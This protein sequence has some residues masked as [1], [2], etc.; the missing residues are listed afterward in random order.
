M[1][2]SYSVLIMPLL[3][4]PRAEQIRSAEIEY[5]LISGTHNASQTETYVIGI[6]SM[7]LPVTVTIKPTST[8]SYHVLTAVRYELLTSLT[9]VSEARQRVEQEVNDELN[10]VI[11][12]NSKLLKEEHTLVWS[13]V[14]H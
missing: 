14:K 8:W 6:A 13:K 12:I 10:A 7:N 2:F 3:S 9:S 11:M 1:L 5:S 4:F